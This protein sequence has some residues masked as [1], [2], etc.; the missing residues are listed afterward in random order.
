MLKSAAEN[1]YPAEVEN[2]AAH[3]PGG[4]RLRG[5][6]RSRRHVGA[7]GE[8]DRRGRRRRDVDGRRAHRAVPR[9]RSRRTRSRGTVEFVDALPRAGFAVDYDELDTAVRRRR[10]SGREH[11]IRLGDPPAV[12][13]RSVSI[14]ALGTDEHDVLRRP[15]SRVQVDRDDHA[16]LEHDV[17][18]QRLEP[19]GP[20]RAG[21]ERSPTRSPG[22]Q[23]P[24]TGRPSHRGRVH[25]SRR[26]GRQLP[27]TPPSRRGGRRPAARR[28]RARRRAGRAPTTTGF[29]RGRR[30]PLRTR[31]W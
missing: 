19:R 7:G 20:R 17:R 5:D 8:G 23:A 16:R 4:R 22:R 3:A 24:T 29:E 2:C 12:R 18:A 11:P 15:R 27:A 26:R 1:I 10:L 13:R 21:S 6:R 9:P 25:G 28:R 14:S 31:A 30:R